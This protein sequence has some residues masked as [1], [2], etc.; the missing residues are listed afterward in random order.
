M[1]LQQAQ[2][3]KVV[4]RFRPPSHDAEQVQFARQVYNLLNRPRKAKPQDGASYGKAISITERDFADHVFGGVGLAVSCIGENETNFLAIDIDEGILSRL[5]VLSRVLQ[6]RGLDKATFVTTGSTA[7]R[8]KVVITLASHIPQDFATGLVKSIVEEASEDPAFGEVRPNSITVFPSS[9]NGSHCRILGH[10]YAVSPVERFGNLEGVEASPFDIIPAAIDAPA[11]KTKTFGVAPWVHTVLTEPFSGNTSELFKLQI[12]LAAEAL[13]DK[14]P[15]ALFLAWMTM[16]ER[17]SSAL[18]ESAK[19]QL[20]RQDLWRRAS[21]YAGT[22]NQY[23][24]PWKPLPDHLTSL[25]LIKVV[26]SGQNETR[27]GF[28][29][30]VGGKGWRAYNALATYVQAFGLN[31]HCFG[32]D[33]ARISDLCGYTDKGTA[34]KAV[35]AAE[36]MQLLS[37]LDN[38]RPHTKERQGAA[39]LFCLRGEGE[40]IERAISLGKKSRAYL[41]RYPLAKAA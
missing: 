8:G 29:K 5:P 38:G 12:R 27:A 2:Q 1:I 31:P 4:K 35:L 36:E 39:T 26:D 3:C 22:Q 20:R 15:E 32:M 23:P 16:L 14:D 11:T 40:T 6:S 21:L 17:N 25:G 7:S 30:V 33:Y 37:R 41:A 28:N 13:K 34:R 9:G 10:K 24:Q 19:R 18:S